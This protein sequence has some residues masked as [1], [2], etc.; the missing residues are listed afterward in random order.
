MSGGGPIYKFFLIAVLLY[1]GVAFM[2]FVL[3]RTILYVPSKKRTPPPAIAEIALVQT[4]DGLALEGW[5]FKPQEGRPVLLYFHGNAGAIKDRLVK[6]PDYLKA[7]YGVLLAEY[8]GYGGNPGKPT[9][10]R[11]YKDGWAYLDWLARERGIGPERIVLYG[12]SLGTGVSVEL[13]AHLSDRGTPPLAVVLEAPFT[14]VLDVAKKNYF[15]IPVD[16]LLLDRY[17][18][19]DKIKRVRAPVF[20]INGQYDEV[21]PEIHGKALFQIANE[22]KKIIQIAGGHHGDLSLFGLSGHVLEFLAGIDSR[23][24]D[25]EKSRTSGE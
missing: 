22:P 18:S 19:R 17:M 12:E 7:G 11:L 9:E 24:G 14:S 5:Y 15:F 16:L 4:A 13:A 23:N 8:R 25:N 20:I 6:I 10:V 1:L 3:Q 21:I 2:L